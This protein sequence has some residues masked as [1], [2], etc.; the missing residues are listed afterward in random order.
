MG[1]PGHIWTHGLQ[2]VQR[3][4]E[5]KR[6]YLGMPDAEPLIKKYSIEYLVVGPQERLVTPVNDR[7]I[8]RFQKVGE[9]GEYQLYKIK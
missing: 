3:E 6:I 1:Y 7:F 8:S 9:V 2:F 5:I 4:G